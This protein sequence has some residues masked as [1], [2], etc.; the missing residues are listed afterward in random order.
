MSLVG[1]EPPSF[2]RRAAE[3]IRLRPRGHWD[4]LRDRIRHIII[5]S[6]FRELGY[7]ARFLRRREQ[8]VMLPDTDL[9]TA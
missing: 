1:F 8:G 2:S 9:Q 6:Y 5:N 4:R 7:N 3:D